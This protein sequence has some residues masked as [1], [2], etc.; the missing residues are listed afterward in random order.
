MKG[1]TR[2]TAKEYAEYERQQKITYHT[3]VLQSLV[4]QM[5]ANLK[6]GFEISNNAI[7]ELEYT[8]NKL[9]RLCP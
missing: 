4:A 2:M 6:N 5:T 9:F 3:R 8:N 1:T 7:F